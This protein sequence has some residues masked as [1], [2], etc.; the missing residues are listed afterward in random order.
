MTYRLPMEIRGV[1]TAERVLEGVVVPYDEV[2]YLTPDPGGERVMRGAFT[3]S[4]AQR[5]DKIFLFRGHDHSHPVGKAVKFT[6]SDDGLHGTFRIRES[7]LGDEA[8]ADLREGYLPGLSVGFTALQR[9]RA[10]DGV[11]EVV[12]GR[13]MEVSLVSIGAYEGAQVL[14]VRTAFNIGH[15]PSPI[16]PNLSPVVPAWVYGAR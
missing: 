11:S 9:R 4:A 2:S 15:H 5:G 14:A 16:P 1:D 10:K 8:L 6:D 13:L 7:V 3:K 12:E